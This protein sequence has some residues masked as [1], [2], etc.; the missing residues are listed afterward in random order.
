MNREYTVSDF[1]MVVDALSELV[2]GMQIATDIICGLPGSL[3]LDCIFLFRSSLNVL[4]FH[5]LLLKCLTVQMK[6][7]N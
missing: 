2:P 4:T 6:I 5:L 3:Q 7:Y 1:K